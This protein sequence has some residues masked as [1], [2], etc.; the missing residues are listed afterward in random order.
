MTTVSVKQYSSEKG[1]VRE[2]EFEP[3][4]LNEVLAVYFRVPFKFFQQA[5]NTSPFTG[6]LRGISTKSRRFFRPL[7]FL[8]SIDSLFKQFPAN[9]TIIC[10]QLSVTSFAR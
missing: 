9:R 6:V 7:K 10:T 4:A 8:V 1:S 2:D 5:I 3:H